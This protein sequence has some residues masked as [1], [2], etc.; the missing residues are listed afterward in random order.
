VLHITEVA[1]AKKPSGKPKAKDNAKEKTTNGGESPKVPETGGGD[2]P[3]W[4]RDNPAAASTYVTLLVLDQL[5]VGIS[6]ADAEKVPLQAL[7]YWITK[8]GVG[9]VAS[10]ARN[11]ARAID[12]EFLK[13]WAARQPKTPPTQPMET[14]E[15]VAVFLS[16][17]DGTI[18]GLVTEFLTHYR[19]A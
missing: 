11:L 17:G 14:V 15:A 10:R 3:K 13:R 8:S 1:V 18:S 19:F 16:K 9:T 12:D 7:L 5:D 4:D 6:F 2:G